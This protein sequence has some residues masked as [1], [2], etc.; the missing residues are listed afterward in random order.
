MI[1]RRRHKNTRLIGEHPVQ[2]FPQLAQVRSDPDVE[3]RKEL[4]ILLPQGQ[5]RDTDRFAGQVDLLWRQHDGVGHF[6][7]CQRCPLDRRGE[8]DHLGL[9]HT[10]FKTLCLGGYSLGIDQSLGADPLGP[11]DGT[12]C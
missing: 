5:G 7:I 10:E 4:S 2:L 3:C 9:S 6:R 8:I 12:E 1:L 11:E